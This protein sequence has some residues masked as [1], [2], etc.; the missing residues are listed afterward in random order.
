MRKHKRNGVKKRE[1]TR[2][3][4][5]TISSYIPEAEVAVRWIAYRFSSKPCLIESEDGKRT[6]SKTPSYYYD[7]GH[8]LI[9]DVKKVLLKT[10]NS[11]KMLL[12]GIVYNSVDIISYSQ[13]GEDPKQSKELAY[14]LGLAFE[15]SGY[16]T[17]IGYS[18]DEH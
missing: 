4:K 8:V 14:R 7:V 6:V 10:P 3:A 12:E 5:Q 13:R 11:K 17:Q 1:L 2:I 9:N 18:E 15:E 16:S